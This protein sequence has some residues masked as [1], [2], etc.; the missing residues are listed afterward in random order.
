MRRAA[1]EEVWANGALAVRSRSRHGGALNDKFINSVDHGMTVESLIFKI[2][3]HLAAGPSPVERAVVLYED[4][5]A[6]EVAGSP[7]GVSIPLMVAGRGRAIA[8]IHTHPV[9]RVAPSLPDLQ[10][11]FAMARLGV[12]QP[13]MVTVYSGEGGVVITV[14][15]LKGPLPPGAEELAARQALSYERLNLDARFDPRVSE[16]QLREQHALLSR[17]GISVERYRLPPVRSV[18]G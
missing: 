18:A 10:V 17:L 16:K 11:L 13:R 2:A 5:S 9:P 4:G 12:E 7:T 3:R 8:V 14:Y 15:T 1:D 6:L